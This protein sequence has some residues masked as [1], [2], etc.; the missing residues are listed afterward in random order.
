LIRFT[1][2]ALGDIAEA[3]DY[4]DQHRGIERAEQLRSSLEVT[5]AR[6]ES[7]PDSARPGR[8]AGTREAVVLNTR[9]LIAYRIVG[10]DIQILAF[11][12]SS[13]KWPDHFSAE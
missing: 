10:D 6:L 2:S 7:F 5:L 4:A 3:L 11:R 9:Y 13:R 1:L 8:V 12:H